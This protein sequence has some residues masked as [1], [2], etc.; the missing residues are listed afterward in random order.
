[1]D[2]RDPNRRPDWPTPP[3]AVPVIRA[4]RERL[5]REERDRERQAKQ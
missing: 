5:A 4:I 2:E 3:G 1:M